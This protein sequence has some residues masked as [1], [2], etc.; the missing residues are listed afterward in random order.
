MHSIPD[1]PHLCECGCGQP[2]DLAKNT[3]SAFGH[4]KGQPLRFR[5]NHSSTGTV[6]PL[7]PCPGCGKLFRLPPSRATR[8]YHCCSQECGRIV[9]NQRAPDRFWA[10]VDKSGG[11]DACWEW[12]GTRAPNRY[13]SV[14][15]H[16]RAVST[17]RL[18]WELTHGPIT[19]GLWVLH[20]CDNPPCCNPAHLFL[21]TPTDNAQDRNA[22]GRANTARGERTGHA[23][24]TDAQVL[25]IR[26]RYAAGET[27]RALA[28]EY[29]VS[30]AAVSNIMTGKRWR[31]L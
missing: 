5:R 20:R 21:G 14:T 13:G 26:A 11:P 19:D 9:F 30:P 24:L 6:Q 15:F 1:S 7:I 29:G 3:I 25:D 23:K 4:V 22:K 28:R 2:T 16:N 8:G 27:G 31:H 17:H 12:Q 18:A 10:K